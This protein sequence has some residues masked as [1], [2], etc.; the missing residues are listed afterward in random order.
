MTTGGGREAAPRRLV[1]R[2]YTCRPMRR[3]VLTIAL[4]ALA[5]VAPG[6][7]AADACGVPDSKPVWIDFVDGTVPFWK[8]RFAR[9]G[10]V[11]ATSGLLLPP[12]LRESGTRTVFW[13]MHLSAR[14]GTPSAPADPAGLDAKAAT[15]AAYAAQS[16]GCATPLIAMNELFGASTPSPWP[17]PTAQYRANVLEWARLLSAR[18][19]RPVLLVSSEPYTAGEA[20]GWWRSLSEVADV[21]LERYVAAPAI[22]RAGAVLGSRRL[23]VAF[24]RPAAQLIAVGVPPGRIGLMV[25][26]QTRRGA[27]GREGLVPAAAWFEEAKWQSFAARQVARELGLAHIWSWGWGSWDERG[28]DRD[29]TGAACAW[30]WARDPALCNAP[31]LLGPTFDAD[32][33]AGQL[34]VPAGVRCLLGKDTITADEIGALARL[35]GDLELAASALFARLVEGGAATIGPAAV[36]EAERAIVARRFGGKRAAYLAALARVHATVDVGRGVIGDELRRRVLAERLAVRAP[37]AREIAD[38]YRTYALVPLREIPDAAAALAGRAT[39]A[40]LLGGLPPAV[41]R[42][43]IVGALRAAARI[44][45][46]RAWSVRV[47][48]SALDRLVCERDR[49]PAV[50]SLELTSFAPF[51]AP[52]AAS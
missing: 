27:G 33:R 5:A 13:D 43:A 52:I 41:A 25:G 36:L 37:T 15:L 7:A 39:A 1:T 31:A 38:F 32:R 23:R 45:A 11:A 16:S 21:V 14:V 42:P 10:V 22:H 28:A 8:E 24:R 9:P 51:L 46:Y 44:E 29:K 34:A 18:G 20:A 19:A 17:A 48:R 2:W 47:Q 40:T 30:L 26:F 49:L 3:L 50:S 4:L 6:P 12:L 35:T